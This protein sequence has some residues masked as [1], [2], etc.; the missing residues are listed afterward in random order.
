MT[1]TFQLEALL[2]GEPS[3]VTDGTKSNLI[4][5]G[6]AR[7]YQKSV[8][9]SVSVSATA[10]SPFSINLNGLVSVNLLALKILDGQS[11]KV[12]VTSAAGTDQAVQVSGLWLWH[13]PVA[14]DVM[15]AVKLV[16]TADVEYLI[17]GS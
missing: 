6:F 3:N 9:A 16:G 17:A 2:T 4:D 13:S 12:L 10:L 5:L 15:T 7:P 8:S 1:H 14:G 11:L